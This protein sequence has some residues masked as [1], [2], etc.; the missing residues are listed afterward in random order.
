MGVKMKLLSFMVG[1]KNEKYRQIKRTYCKAVSSF[2]I[3]H[4]SE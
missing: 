2:F 4:L 1:F 3:A